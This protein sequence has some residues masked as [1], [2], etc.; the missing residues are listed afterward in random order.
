MTSVPAMGWPA[1]HGRFVHLY[2]NGLYW[3]LYNLTER[4]DPSFAASYMG[5][6]KDNWDIVS[7][8]GPVGDSSMALWDAM[9]ALLRQGVSSDQAYERL[10]GNNPDGNRNPEYVPYLDIDNY[11]DYMILNFFVGNSDWPEVNWYAGIDRADPA[12]FRFFAWDAECTVGLNSDVTLDCTT[13]DTGVAEPYAWLLQKPNSEQDSPRGSRKPS[14]PTAHSPSIPMKTVPL[15]S[16][17][18]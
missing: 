7:A 5:G 9:L 16:T 18:S 12:G 14:P 15:P 4:P 6:D 11:I 10:L 8:G 17:P 13:V 1:P 2:I 3:G